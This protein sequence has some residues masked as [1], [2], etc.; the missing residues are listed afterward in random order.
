[1]NID[2]H[3]TGTDNR[4]ITLGSISV[5]ILKK[6]AEELLLL[7]TEALGEKEEDAEED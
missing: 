4:V 3:L 6:D 1:M 7:L 5:E 2:V